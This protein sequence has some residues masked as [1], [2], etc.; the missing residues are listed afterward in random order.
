MFVSMMAMI[1]LCGG[2]KS[3]DENIQSLGFVVN[4]SLLQKP[5]IDSILKISFSP[6]KN[7]ISTPSD[8]LLKLVEKIVLEN[9]IGGEN[10]HMYCDRASRSFLI[11]N[12]TAF[13]NGTGGPESL[14]KL[15]DLCKKQFPQS[16]TRTIVFLKK[17]FLVNQII[18]NLGTM[19]L[20]SL[21]FKS[22]ECRPFAV[23]FLVPMATFSEH[24][25][26]VESV[27]GSVHPIGTIK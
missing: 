4:D 2:P 19:V 27:V 22:D 21:Y 9:K 18:A 16:E 12:Q 15:E 8:T 3:K 24:M 17:P 10:T 7:W 23:N 20:V 5:V 6:P 13:F 1:C 11:V 26:I 14:K 25:K